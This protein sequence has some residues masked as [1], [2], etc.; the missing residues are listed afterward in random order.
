M[1]TLQNL[2]ESDSLSTIVDKLNQNF[3][4]ISTS[5]GGPIGGRGS[6]GIPG[7]PG[8]I[9][10][11]GPSGPPGSTG[12]ASYMIP[13]ADDS[14]GETGPSSIAGP[15]PVS[16]LD[17]LTSTVGTGGTGDIF[18]DHYN[19]GYWM[20]L[21][22]ADGTGQYS[23]VGPTYP[24]SGTG[25]YG[26]AGWYFYPQEI[27]QNVTDVWSYDYT[28]YFTTPPYATGPFNDD[29]L[30]IP[31]A[32]FNS[33]Y[34]TIWVSSG[35]SGATGSD[36]YYTSSIH[37]WGEDY[38]TPALTYA[39]PGRW[40]GGVDRLLF[41]F[42]LDALPYHS[43]I[44][45]RSITTPSESGA[46]P[47]LP[48]N[49]Y[50]Q[51]SGIYPILGNSYWTKPA[52][53]TSLDKYT[54]LFF[55][56][57]SKPNTPLGGEERFASLG[58]FQFTAVDADP[59]GSSGGGITAGST[60]STLFSND[61]K[62]VFLLSTRLSP[63]PEDFVSMGSSQTLNNQ[64]TINISELI[65]DVKSLSTT[66]QMVVGLPQD[67]VLSSDFVSGGD[68]YR[69]ASSPQAYKVF[70]GYISAANGKNI[71]GDVSITNYIDYGAGVGSPSDPNTPTAGNQTRRSWYGSAFRF[72][73]IS[74][75]SNGVS[76]PLDEG[77]ARLAGMVERGKKSWNASNDTHFLSELIF[78]TSQFKVNA[79]NLSDL[80]THSISSQDIDWANN[81]QKSLPALY[82]SPFRNIGVGTFT[83][84]DLGVWE[85]RARLHSHVNPAVLS[86]DNDPTNIW[87]SLPGTISTD[88]LVINT[89]VSRVAAFTSSTTGG[90]NQGFVDVYLG[91][92][93]PP[94]YEWANPGTTGSPTG[95]NTT[96]SPFANLRIALRRE[97]WYN[98]Q[99]LDSLRIGVLAGSTAGSSDI[100]SSLDSY[101][102]E[103][104]LGIHPLNTNATA[105]GNTANAIA[106]V[107]IHNLWPRTRFH[108][109][110]KNKY[111]EADRG[112]QA[113]YP[114]YSY[115]AQ[116][117]GPSGT[118]PYY[119]PNYASANQIVA[120]FIKDSYLYPT[121][122]LEYNYQAYGGSPLAGVGTASVGAQSAN[123]AAYP[124]RELA[125]PTR[126]F[127]PFGQTG[128]NG[129]LYGPH[130]NS[131]FTGIVSTTG[132][133]NN[134]YRHGG[135]TGASFKPTN[136]LGFNL[137]RDLVNVGDNRTDTNTW[138]LGTNGGYENGGSAIL[139]NGEGDIAITTIKA[140]RDGGT[141]YSFW[142]QKVS[143][144]DVLNNIKVIIG[145][146]G[147]VGF[148]NKAGFDNNAYASQERDL[149]TG[150][151][152]YVPRSADGNGLTAGPFTAGRGINYNVGLLST[153][154]YGLVSYQGLSAGW[155]ETSALS[156]A[157]RV[158]S[159]GT[160]SDSFRAEFAADKLFGRPGR[161]IQN[162]GWGYPASNTI[163]INVNGD[164]RKYIVLKSPY[165]DASTYNK[166][167][168][169]VLSTDL[170]GR[171]TNAS[172]V[173]S[174][175]GPTG[176]SAG[177]NMTEWFETVMLPHPTEFET[178]GP[179]NSYISGATWAAPVGAAAGSWSGVTGTY[180]PGTLTTTLPFAED[181]L[182]LG[183]VRLNNFVAGEGL[184]YSGGSST[185]TDSAAVKTARQQ[186]PKLVFT[187]MEGDSS[188]IPGST[189]TSKPV[190]GTPGYRKVNTVVASAQNESSLREYW[191]PKS[192]NTGGTFMVFTDHYGQKEKDAG[193]DN[194]TIDIDNL[195]I[196]EIVTLEFVIGYTG[197]NNRGITGAT[198][199]GEFAASN[200]PGGTAGSSFGSDISP[201]TYPAGTGSWPAYVYYKN[202]DLNESS[203]N[204]A[205]GTVNNINGM[206]AGVYG[207][208]VPIGPQP[209]YPSGGYV[210]GYWGFPQGANLPAGTG[211]TGSTLWR[212][213]DKYYSIYNPAT[214]YENGWGSPTLQN[215]A[216]EVRFKRINSEFALFDF[217]I[218]V[219][220]RNPNMEW[221]L[222]PGETPGT[223]GATANAVWTEDLIDRGS[224]RW[225]QSI[226]FKYFPTLTDNDHNTAAD[227]NNFMLNLYG[228]GLGFN[229]WSS[230][231]NWYPGTAMVGPT[232]TAAAV[233]YGLT[234][235]GS[236]AFMFTNTA[237]AAGLGAFNSWNGNLLNYSA[238]NV[239]WND[240]AGS[241]P[242]TSVMAVVPD[243]FGSTGGVTTSKTFVSTNGL[244]ITGRIV[245]P[246]LSRATSQIDINIPIPGGGFDDRRQGF[247]QSFY[248]MMW[249][250][251]GNR[252][253]SRQRNCMWRLIPQYPN[254]YGPG[255]VAPSTFNQ[256]RSTFVLEVLFD[257][258]ILHV[259]V[260]L[261]DTAW[262]GATQ[263]TNT[264]NQWFKYLTLNG[265][266]IV[267]YAND[268][269]YSYDVSPV[270]TPP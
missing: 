211:V 152:N 33:K 143:T 83:A 146:D 70:Q 235:D 38:G 57:E 242:I 63:T 9:G 144:R 179:L 126:H 155:A 232:A 75:W 224:P 243:A 67:M 266:S 18:I 100:G 251:M 56:S 216:T 236:P 110:G 208:V 201:Y 137:F 256:N 183:N 93:V 22:S 53:D 230:Y 6:V 80:A 197:A 27:T 125:S 54:P 31:N 245:W 117:N 231:R 128:D 116:G 130:W 265:Q 24:P 138:V 161:T 114:G 142:E 260:P 215:K 91:R 65:L 82:I 246:L 105:A 79:G 42:S 135:A 206:T 58:L 81:E 163:T 11:T 106:G 104:Q 10:A 270:P 37:N 205:T 129:S 34:G 150:F 62:S 73:D 8:K 194:T 257:E 21:T 132:A 2:L 112:D 12:P 99:N 264:T 4:I 187:F 40:N 244:D 109:F 25:F 94:G 49:S 28:T 50:P 192:D 66:N 39:Q 115:A 223:T 238:I 68:T 127:I 139:T 159:I 46:D 261:R 43:A 111:N 122:I 227:W 1:L 212:N 171:L 41:K 26:G 124:F 3:Q 7:L 120:D 15:W 213:L 164:I 74:D 168:Q 84:D 172:V 108:V 222:A 51:I 140:G 86:A 48:D 210:G 158:N 55:W 123:A 160:V 141:S 250:V 13:F 203:I 173:W 255:G 229:N 241:P 195:V 165:D 77:Y 182:I 193:I 69:E 17:Y 166:L 262:G 188:P 252:A 228:N 64:R 133:F 136:Y 209:Q 72:D 268:A 44:K 253:F 92:S 167:S 199:N 131:G 181:P 254:T 147:S 148:G 204:G 196:D 190:A 16:S 217:N 234:T 157:A 103:F 5:G 180:T 95:A 191:I 121:G 214:N 61:K 145:K 47:N 267:R 202:R 14:S 178:G 154:A 23:G 184:G 185:T 221:D 20:Y 226:R 113:I 176:A 175:G 174:S 119:N 269:A 85:P 240:G 118:Y 249:Q 263:S 96:S 71:G 225:T 29:T 186:S 219:A 162:G 134:S 32:R 87:F 239:A 98:N 45:A 259:D 107:G 78:Y 90:N 170:E 248:A 200:L 52:Y 247:F 88:P 101:R 189:A 153:N 59:Y 198:A 36:D 97:G 258:P 35:N 169:F 76:N 102:N 89:E 19:K 156:Y 218:T 149:S 151:V 207:R 237:S 177:S 220:V 233:S 30:K 60:A